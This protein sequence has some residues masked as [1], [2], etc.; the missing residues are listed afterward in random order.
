MK[1]LS[2]LSPAELNKTLCT[3]S[4]PACR[5]FSAPDVSD[6]FK[7]IGD[8]ANE[9]KGAPMAFTFRILSVMSPTFLSE[10]H[11]ADTHAIVAE[12]KGVSAEEVAAQTG[13]QTLRDMWACLMEDKEL[14]TFFRPV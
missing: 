13:M 2:Q 10:E 6:V 4:G 9:T 5:L 11:A 3:I 7:T 14:Y 1:K 12:M 8:I